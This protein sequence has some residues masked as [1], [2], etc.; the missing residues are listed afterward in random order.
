MA[1]AS[2]DRQPFGITWVL[3]EPMTRS[4]HAL[5]DD[6]R[7]WLIDPTAVPEALDQALE[8]GRPAAVLQLLDRHGRGCEAIAA[9]LGVPHF[10]VPAALP[11]TPF[12]VIPVV[13]N[14]LWREVA[15]WWP[16]QGVLVVTEAVGT[17]ASFAP[18]PE[19]AGV[20]IGLRLWPPRVLA[21]Y[22]PTHLLVGHGPSLHGSTAAVALREALDRSMSDVPR[23]VVALA[24]AAVDTV[25]R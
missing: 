9:G 8:L 7:V 23:A 3:D 6:G 20:H 11:D 16:G 24:K 17:A 14:K 12:K 18:G 21:G 2:L 5:V 22:V 19:G 13:D 1:L 10:K 15:L 25:R 4:S